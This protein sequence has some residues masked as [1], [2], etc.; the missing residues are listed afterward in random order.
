MRSLSG[1]TAIYKPLLLNVNPKYGEENVCMSRSYIL[2]LETQKIELHFENTEYEA[3]AP[4]QKKELSAFF[5]WSPIAEAWVSKAKEPNLWRSKQIAEKLG[6]SK[7]ERQGKRLSFAE[8][9]EVKSEKAEARAER[10]EQYSSN[11]ADRGEALQRAFNARREDIAFLTQPITAGRQVE[12]PLQTKR[13]E[14]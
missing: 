13:P 2:N 14:S 1:Y 5:L 4:E 10:L 9:V 11:A 3:L 12:G 6:F 8:Q 7:E